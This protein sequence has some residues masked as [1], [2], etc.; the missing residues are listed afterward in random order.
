MVRTGDARGVHAHAEPDANTAIASGL[1]YVSDKSR[2]DASTF[3][4]Q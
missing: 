3:L 2:T 4:A 1:H